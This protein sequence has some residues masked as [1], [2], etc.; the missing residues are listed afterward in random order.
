MSRFTDLHVPISSQLSKLYC[1][2]QIYLFVVMFYTIIAV[3]AISFSFVAR[4]FV[5]GLKSSLKLFVT[6]IESTM[7]GLKRTFAIRMAL[8]ERK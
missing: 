7:D 1:N 4:L 8:N 2:S 3:I 5:V 6:K